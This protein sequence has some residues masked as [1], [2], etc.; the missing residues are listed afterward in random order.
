MD[1]NLSESFTAFQDAD[2]DSFTLDDDPKVLLNNI[3]DA[4]AVSP[5]S[6][7]R[8]DVFDSLQML[9]NC[10]PKL[11][12]KKIQRELAYIVFSS[13]NNIAQ[14]T[15]NIIEN[16]ERDS[17]LLYKKYLELYGY[18]TYCLLD[19]FSK[20]DFSGLGKKDKKTIEN[21][22]YQNKELSDSMEAIIMVLKINL[23]KLFVTTPERDLFISLFT[24]P[25]YQL[26]E[27]KERMKNNTVKLL[28]FRCISMAVK[29]H[30]H[31]NVAQGS[32]I[33]NLTFFEHLFGP[34]AELLQMLTDQYD[35][36]Q[37]TEEIL[38]ELSN[39]EYS[40]KDVNVPKTIAA[41]LTRLSEL[42]P[43]VVMKQMT[44][45]AQLLDNNS[46]TLR[47][48]V[49]EACGNIIT[50]ICKDKEMYEIHKEQVDKF[51]DLLEG[52]LLDQYHYVRS[53]ALQ[54][55]TKL[56]T[57][58]VKFS[59]RRQE[60]LDLTVRSL[61]DKS[62]F[63]RKCAL[64]LITELVN[65]HS[66]SLLHGSQLDSEVWKARLEATEHQLEELDPTYKAMKEAEKEMLKEAQNFDEM[67]VDEEGNDEDEDG[68]PKGAQQ[69]G[70]EEEEEK[71]KEEEEEQ[72][73]Q[74][75]DDD[76]DDD[77]D[78]NNAANLSVI[79]D[80]PIHKD[81]ATINNIAKLKL[82]IQY[83]IDAL[84]FI[85]SLE[86]ALELTSQLLYSKN[87]TDVIAAMEF[88]VLAN[89]Y[90]IRG[91]EIGIKRMLHLVWMKNGNDENDN[92]PK[93]LVEC[94][95]HL[96]LI[97]PPNTSAIQHASYVAKNLCKL[98]YNASVADLASLEKLIYLMYKDK[99]IDD[100][101]IKVLWQI[102]SFQQRIEEITERQ[103]RKQRRGAIII[104]GMLGLADHTIALKGLD[105]LL[106]IGLG[107]NGKEDLILQRYSCIAIQ[108]IIPSA[109]NV[110][111]VDDTNSNQFI[112]SREKEVIEKVTNI[113]L[114]YTEDHE[115]YSIAEQ[116]VSAIYGI[117]Q[118]PDEVCTEIIKRKTVEV[119]GD[120]E[121]NN[122]AIIGLSQLLF[123]VGH[124]AIKTI[125]YLEKLETQFKKK[126]LQIE[127]SKTQNDEDGAQ[128]EN[129]DNE[130][131]MIGG[132]SEDDFADAVIS[133]K[134]HHLLYD[135]NSILSRF[136]DIVKVICQSN[137]QYDNIIL[138]RS[139][140][141]CLSKLMLISSKYCEE[142]LP[143]LITIMER[144]PDP[145]IRSNAVLAL[146]DMAVVFNNLVDD[147]TDFLYR[148]LNDDNIM[149]QRTCLMTV[150]FL[151][152]A[153]Q[154]KVKGQLS[155][156][157]KCLEN[158]DQGISDMCKMFFTE[159]AT[160]DNAIYNSF[161]DLFSGLSNDEDLEQ[162]SFEKIV[163]F[164]I[165]FI[166][167]EKSN[168]KHIKQLSTKLLQRLKKAE[169]EKQWKSVKFVLNCLEIK[170]EELDK[171]IKDAINEG[172]N[173]VSVEN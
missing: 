152:L 74:K 56:C 109:K 76:D 154:V 65:N 25:I 142:N 8:D 167:R 132:T 19:Y 31:A 110:E 139:A 49:I 73:Q 107:E 64:E 47:S 143:L 108:R 138:Q 57:L 103:Q 71:N 42:I 35:Y 58:D 67:D 168:D 155:Q 93:K 52:R 6:I 100:M 89:A 4:L 92:I 3:T 10:Y 97:S 69:D 172:Y 61:Q 40:E 32:I 96:F 90:D 140:T 21:F 120:S 162:D 118:A 133:I 123:I 94:Y 127:Q 44:L 59:T 34:L 134:E 83:Y 144:S 164:V 26:M 171:E 23:S 161:I 79:N 156:M 22:N 51:I 166:N 122:G 14:N 105:L 113:L 160:K 117:S 128:K 18:A 141:L 99:L 137:Y 112:M 66:F 9:V 101:I 116:A 53:K 136:K 11:N 78:A 50:N 81:Q 86:K 24:R 72:Q 170:N 63:V 7:G 37:L 125:V 82:T 126:K 115:W 158:K 15:I 147:N 17:F 148:R 173:M 43:R 68:T 38:R 145:I 1:F 33:S 29:F 16:G 106:S 87:K 111:M 48:A 150:T 80:D 62:S 131:E 60:F 163:K 129:P 45:I 55:M 124:V 70:D 30:G 121:N 157:A 77:D 146:G 149:V 165:G 2:K 39:K 20:E 151:I 75:E 88:F 5:E 91:N 159:L 36:S 130:L 119:L 84:K 46:S 153:G 95:H 85:A 169:S 102:Y 104:L 27:F 135:S 41:F 98:T 12:S 54:T 13:M 114:Y 28:M